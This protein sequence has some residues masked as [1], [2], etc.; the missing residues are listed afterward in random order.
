MPINPRELPSKFHYLIPL[1]E[2]HG[3]DAPIS[4]FNKKLGR[5]VEYAEKLKRAQ[6]QEL[7]QLYLTINSKNQGPSIREWHRV[8]S[9][10]NGCVPE[11]AWPIHGL[12]CLFGQLARLG[13]SPFNDGGQEDWNSLRPETV[14]DWGKL[15]EPLRF[16]AVPAEY[17]GAFQFENEVY[18]FL[19]EKMTEAQLA[20]LKQ[21][22]QRCSEHWKSIDDWIKRNPISKHPESCLVY[23]TISLIASAKDLG[24]LK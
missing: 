16:L 17:Y 10:K 22:D 18:E 2:Q 23:F 8:Y 9:Q 3:N 14:L 1:A 24:I 7:A 11:T 13:V 5:H 20:D 12:I 15:P 19:Q 4:Q 6:I 21:L